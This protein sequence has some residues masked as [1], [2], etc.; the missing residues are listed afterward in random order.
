[1]EEDGCKYV[2]AEKDGNTAFKA[3]NQQN[4]LLKM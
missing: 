1:L 4:G 2:I 3:Q